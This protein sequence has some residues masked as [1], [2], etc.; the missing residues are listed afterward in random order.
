M[1]G[2]SVVLETYLGHEALRV[3]NSVIELPDVDFE[4]GTIEFDITTTGQRSFIGVA[5]RIEERGDYEDF[6]LRPHN[7]G[8]FDAMQYTP[9]YNGISA[10]QLY[11][12][13]N[14]SFDIPTDTWLH[15]RLVISGSELRVYFDDAEAATLTIEAL[16]RGR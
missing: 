11:P 10:W 12:E 2:D 15:V 6:Y 1:R 7:S 5:F 13:Y 14:A 4:N 3:R 8:R 9:V 16:K